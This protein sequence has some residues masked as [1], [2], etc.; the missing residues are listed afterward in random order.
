ML[1]DTRVFGYAY[2][3]DIGVAY[4]WFIIIDEPAESENL[5]KTMRNDRVIW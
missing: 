5:R 3:L 4:R 2:M 1:I